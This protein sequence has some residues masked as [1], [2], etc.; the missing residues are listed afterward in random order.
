MRAGASVFDRLVVRLVLVTLAAGIAAAVIGTG[1]LLSSGRSNLRDDLKAQHQDSSVEL[2]ERVDGRVDAVLSTLQVVATRTRVAS[3]SP[4]ASGDLAAVL[5]AS[6]RFDELIIRDARG[7]PVAAAAERF[8][9]APADYETD[10]TLFAAVTDGDVIRLTEPNASVLELTV[11]IEN[12]PGVSAGTL[13]ARAPLEV[14][15]S[16]ILRA[17]ARGEAVR[18]LVHDDGMVVVHPDR[19]R[20]VGRDAVNLDELGQLPAA[21]SVVDG[22][23]LLRAAAPVARFSGAVVVEQSESV[24]LAPVE[25]RARELVTILVAV[26]GSAV[27]AISV[28]GGYLLRPLAPLA[29]S[30]AQLGRGRREV[31]V[32]AV[33]SGEVATL[34]NEFN[35]LADALERREREVDELQRVSLLLHGQAAR[36]DVVE[37]IV[38]GAQ[39][40]LEATAAELWEVRDADVGP[41]PAGTALAA[42]PAVREL[43]DAA[44]RE[45]TPQVASTGESLAA[46][47]VRGLDQS[48]SGVLVVAREKAW[49]ERGLQMGDALAAVAG[50]A[51]E[52]LRRLELERQLA[53]ELQHASDRRRDFMGTVTHEFRTPLTCIEGFSSLLLEQWDTQDDQERRRFVEK[54]H[55]H[56]EE[57]DELVSRLLDFAVTERG[58]LSA[59]L[60]PV[61]LASLVDEV[62]AQLAP[63]LG[64]RP[65]ERHVDDVTVE[66]DAVLLRRTLTNLLSNAV[67]YSQPGTPIR[68]RTAADGSLVRV[69][70]ED[71]GIGMDADEVSRAFT[72]FWRAGNPS[73]RGSRGAG[74]GLSLVAEYVR[75]MRGTVDVRS[76]P[77]HGSVFSFTLRRTAPS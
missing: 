58:T 56:S 3:V 21:E 43:A 28:V 2:A 38:S 52:N 54:I 66:A 17:P 51:I 30:I 27:V 60:A 12:P 22:R 11:G 46:F 48:P 72:P 37:Q 20:V 53:E 63:V 6:D 39:A 15:L 59:E 62:V 42:R 49:D 7:V 47:P 69:D 40:V 71:E 5:R 32:D 50:V 35:R 45:T 33:G 18:Y 74:I 23:R 68:I 67:K 55:R 19:D 1:L 34:T 75:S 77:G 61:A 9:A 16:G 64:G 73:T 41:R 44:V 25:E 65:L 24:A 36:S 29:A 4:E 8:L 14:I 57:L 70:V 26:I 76:Q 13:T 31:R 10:T